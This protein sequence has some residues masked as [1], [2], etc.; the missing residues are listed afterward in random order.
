MDVHGE[1]GLPRHHLPQLEARLQRGPHHVL[2]AAGNTTT[3]T[4]TDPTAGPDE[5]LVPFERLMIKR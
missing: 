1:E 5:A 2:P 3:T 4:T